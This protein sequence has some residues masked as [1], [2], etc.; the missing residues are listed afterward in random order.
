MILWCLNHNVPQKEYYH[1]DRNVYRHR[2]N[3][4]KVA[5]SHQYPNPSSRNYVYGVLDGSPCRNTSARNTCVA[6][7]STSAPSQSPARRW[8][9]SLNGSWT[10][11]T[12][13]MTGDKELF[14]D[15]KLTQSSQSYITF[16]D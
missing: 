12:N 10:V 16:G 15:E 4:D 3:N 11:S 2:D 6:S 5:Y 8:T 14:T 13:H 7:T 9:M 1:L